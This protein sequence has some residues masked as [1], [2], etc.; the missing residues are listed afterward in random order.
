MKRRL[1]SWPVPPSGQ[2]ATPLAFAACTH[3]L[4]A[5]QAAVLL[6]SSSRPLRDLPATLARCGNVIPGLPAV[7]AGM[8]CSA[9]TC[10]LAATAGGGGRD[11]KARSASAF[12]LMYQLACY[13]EAGSTCPAVQ[14]TEQ[15]YSPADSRE[16]A[17]A[18]M[19]AAAAGA[20]VTP[21]ASA[22]AAALRV[23][24]QTAELWVRWG[25]TADDWCVF[26]Q[27][28]GRRPCAQ[29]SCGYAGLGLLFCRHLEAAYGALLA[30]AAPGSPGAAGTSSSSGGSSTSS[31]GSG[32]SAPGP[33]QAAAAVLNV[34][35]LERARSQ[36][37][38]LRCAYCR[39]V[40]VHV[41]GHHASISANSH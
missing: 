34:A 16:A 28:R 23:M 19:L 22:S 21:A 32:G 6:G 18:G 12:E 41:V 39:V 9:A 5:I 36:A 31:G 27:G 35:C 15:P 11:D 38:C 13:S 29:C 40:N 1:P 8:V 24:G 4:Q 3:N 10:P 20:A 33:G 25:P 30:P 17:V 26:R 2:N 7:P 14:L 37:S